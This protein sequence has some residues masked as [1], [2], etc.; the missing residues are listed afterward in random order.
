MLSGQVLLYGDCTVTNK[1]SAPHILAVDIGTTSIK[2]GLIA[3]DGTIAGLSQ[4]AT[5]YLHTSPPVFEVD[6]DALAAAALATLQACC[7]A[8]D[9]DALGAIAVTAQG[10]GVWPL[11]RTHRP[12][13]PASIWR[14]SRSD[15]VLR[16]WRREGRLPAVARFTGAYPTSAHQTTQCAW[17]N[18][19]APERIRAAHKIV[20]AEDWIGYLLTGNL[21]VCMSNYEHTYGHCQQEQGRITQPAAEVLHL[22]DLAWLEPLLPEPHS[23][24]RARGMLQRTIANR[25]GVTP[26]IPVFVGPFDVLTA[27]LGVGAVDLAQASSIWGTAAIHQRWVSAFS[28]LEIGYLV[29][30]P[31]VTDR[32]LRF[33]A[34]SAGMVNL[35]YWRNLLF[36]DSSSPIDWATIEA[37]LTHLANEAGALLYLPYLTAADERSEP[38]AGVFG[39]GFLGVQEHHQK[40]DFLRAVYE[41]L[42]LQAARI[43]RR[44]D[45]LDCPLQEVRVAGGGGQSALLSGLLASAANLRVV[46]PDATEASL[47]GAAMVALVGL[48]YADSIDTLAQTMVHPQS[49]YEPDPKAVPLYQ[50]AA[51]SIDTLLA[52]LANR[53]H[54]T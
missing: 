50:E 52:Q 30:H 49:V 8:A 3:P 25:L 19:H 31:Q 38:I 47:L 51:A 5:P 16:R 9:T 10:D 40:H 23:P 54:I 28:P 4:Q 33:V 42:A 21:G 15:A 41:G 20:F 48:G 34:T 39:A 13:G 44:L 37:Q 24:L 53:H 12:A 17:L 27:A 7:T 46:R 22:L 6:M 1:S 32:W 29:S 43:F 14:D 11:D 45:P 35:D 36:S 26:G 2:A 18:I